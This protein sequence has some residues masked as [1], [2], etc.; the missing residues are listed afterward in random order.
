M[1]MAGTCLVFFT[2]LVLIGNLLSD[3][4]LAWADP[5]IRYD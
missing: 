1:Y 5:R 2:G 4:A 3:L